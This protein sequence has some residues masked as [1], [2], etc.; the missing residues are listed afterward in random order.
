MEH[1]RQ[2]VLSFFEKLRF[3]LLM[4]YSD[5][6]L[7]DSEILSKWEKDHEHERYTEIDPVAP[8]ARRH[9]TRRGDRDP[10]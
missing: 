8:V 10:H 4:H 3:I 2:D 7:C 6:T 9:D 1:I 5:I